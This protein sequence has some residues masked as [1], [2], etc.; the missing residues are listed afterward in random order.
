MQWDC[1]HL[2]TRQP[3]VRPHSRGW[4]HIKEQDINP[5]V[6]WGLSPAWEKRTNVLVTVSG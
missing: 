5:P 6:L 4:R 3:G 2:F 1:V